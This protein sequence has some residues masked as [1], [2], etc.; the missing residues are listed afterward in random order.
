MTAFVWSARVYWEDTDG[1]GVVYYAN[2]LK[3]FERARSEWLRACGHSQL[4]LASDPGVLFSVIEVNI[5]YRLPA[6][7]DDL[8]L[9]SCLPALDG[10]ATVI[11]QQQIHRSNQTLDR[12]PELLA[13]ATVRVACVNAVNFRP[14]RLP[15][16]IAKELKTLGSAADGR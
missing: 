16:G 14:R 5:K 15:A 13:E 8:L 2:Y 11:F 3:F 4:D 6:R 7:L 12:S 10:A 1:G 9:I